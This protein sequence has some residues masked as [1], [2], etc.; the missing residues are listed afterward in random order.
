MWESVYTACLDEGGQG[1]GPARV[2]GS[3][4]P[5]V[6]VCVCTRVCDS[7]YAHTSVPVRL[8]AWE[9]VSGSAWPGCPHG[10]WWRCPQETG[11]WPPVWFCLAALLCA[12]C[13]MNWSPG[14]ST[15][16]LEGSV[17]F[18]DAGLF[19]VRFCLPGRAY[20]SSPFRVMSLPVFQG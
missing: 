5:N 18:E 4:A 7:V 8:A 17:C 13:F 6:P 14:S 2:R 1:R 3:R 20:L 16:L 15:S 9:G 10:G 12:V 19:Q 11:S